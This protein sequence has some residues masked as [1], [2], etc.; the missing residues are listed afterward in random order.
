MSRSSSQLAKDAALRRAL[1]LTARRRDLWN[2]CKDTVLV[3]LPQPM[4]SGWERYFYLRPELAHTSEAPALDAVLRLTQNVERS[5]RKDFARRDWERGGKKRAFPHAMQEIS[6]DKFWDNVP[7]ELRRY[8]EPITHREKSR[9]GARPWVTFAVKNPEAR[10]VSR[11][12]PYYITHRALPHSEADS[13]IAR[14]ESELY[15]PSDWL[16]RHL[17]RHQGASKDWYP[18]TN[19]I[20]PLVEEAEVDQVSA[21]IAHRG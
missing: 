17:I 11:T 10:Y 13:E 18:D 4:R 15:G 19:G 16:A 8:F 9:A 1:A 6:E 5:N 2:S 21:R 7:A 3:E 14:I 20:P 12:R